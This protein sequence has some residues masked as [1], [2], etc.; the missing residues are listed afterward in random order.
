[1]SIYSRDEIN[2]Q[3]EPAPWP[4]A[5]DA[6][7]DQERGFHERAMRQIIWS[8]IPWLSF[9]QDGIFGHSKDWLSSVDAAFFATSEDEDLLLIE[10]TWS[11]WPDPPRWGLASRPSSELNHQWQRWGHF[12]DLPSAW[13]LPARDG[14]GSCDA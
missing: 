11:G 2:P 4:M 12:P 9:P 14:A 8:P 1:V 5:A 6:A 10:N 7:N 13:T 3:W